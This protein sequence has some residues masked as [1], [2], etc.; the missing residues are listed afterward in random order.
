[1]NLFLGL[2]C[3]RKTP[4]LSTIYLLSRAFCMTLLIT[5]TMS[6]QTLAS[7]SYVRFWHEADIRVLNLHV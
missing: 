2:L 6:V 5:L 4:S 7:V 1:M 3:A